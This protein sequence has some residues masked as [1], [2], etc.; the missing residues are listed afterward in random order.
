MRRLI[1]L[2]RPDAARSLI[3]KRVQWISLPTNAERACME[4][5]LALVEGAAKALCESKQDRVV[6]HQ[7]LDAVVA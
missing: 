1:Q 5:V 2:W 4:I 3:R 7:P 6:L